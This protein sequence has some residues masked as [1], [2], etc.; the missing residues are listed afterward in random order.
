[1]IRSERRAMPGPLSR[2]ELI[3]AGVSI[4]AAS[5][6]GCTREQPVASGQTRVSLRLN[7]TPSA[8]HAIFY[9]GI[10]QGIYADEGIDLRILPGTGSVD[11][12]KLVSA[13]NDMFGTA[14]ADAVVIGR[15]RG[16]QVASLA[17]LLQRSANVLCSLKQAG[18]VQPADLLGKSVGVNVRSTSHAFWKALLKA[19]NLDEHR[20]KTLDLGAAAPA[21][22][23]IAG[24]IDAA[25]LLATNELK[26][27]QAQG[28][29][30]NTIDPVDYGVRSYGQ[31]LFTTDRLVQTQPQLARQ[32]MRATLRSLE[33]AMNNVPQAVDAMKQRVPE[34]DAD[35]EIAKWSEIVPRVRGTA[36]NAVPPGSQDID[37][38]NS[39]IETFRAAGLIEGP[40][41]AADLMAGV[42]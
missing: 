6:V 17:V 27:L 21:G 2:R 3:A 18:I 35:I 26:T 8:E 33:S 37:G 11:A 16:A 20:I 7:W 29:E 14:V 12:V 30:L 13:G 38:W 23:L 41:A 25:M 39:T 42:A 24:T 10:Q 1:M 5:A 34:I 15:S 32:M 22:P 4:L 36:S 40:L 28:I 31:V 19:A 9:L